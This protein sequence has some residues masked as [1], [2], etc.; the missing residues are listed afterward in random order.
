M[1]LLKARL[2]A[3][4]NPPEIGAGAVALRD[5]E[6]MRRCRSQE[7]KFARNSQS[8]ATADALAGR[9]DAELDAKF[10]WTGRRMASL[11]TRDASRE[12]LSPGGV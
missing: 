3:A 4:W 7:Q 5:R 9:S 1:I 12:K 6:R 2:K 8:S 10:G 11:Y